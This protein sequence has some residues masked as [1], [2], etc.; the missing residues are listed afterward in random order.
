[1]LGR[2]LKG[3]SRAAVLI[4][5]TSLVP[6][7]M[8][9]V[10][11]QTTPSS[12][13]QTKNLQDRIR[14]SLLMLSYYGV[15]D[16]IG[17]KIQ[18]DTVTLVGEVKRPLLKDEA[19]Q[20]V[21]KLDGVAKVVNDIEILPLS[22]MDDSLRSM[23]FKAIYS[24]P[25]FEKYGLQA[26]KPIRIIVKNGNITLVGMVGSE[27]DKIEAEMAA[28]SVPFAFSIKNELTIG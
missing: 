22:S 8:A 17:Y 11:K 25:G 3:F 9:S 26:I 28:R 15:F 7:G 12:G 20:V 10:S 1:M 21:R 24:R 4:F 13:M 27:F 2:N 19:E 23:T 14:H 18:G 5:L 6:V 16:E